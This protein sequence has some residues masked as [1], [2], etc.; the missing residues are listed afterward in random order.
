MVD[1][2]TATAS[3]RQ[4]IEQTLLL[5]FATYPAFRYLWP[6]SV[7]YLTIGSGF[8]ML[9]VKSLPTVCQPERVSTLALIISR[10]PIM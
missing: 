8:M 2:R 4:G 1:V 9:V 5:S 3:D 10:M 7:D 6:R